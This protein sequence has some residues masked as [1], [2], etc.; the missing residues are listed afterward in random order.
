MAFCAT[1]EGQATIQTLK[2]KEAAKGLL[3][4]DEKS[5]KAEKI[6]NSHVNLFEAEEELALNA[7]FTG[8][9]VDAPENSNKSALNKGII[10]VPLGGN[11]SSNRKSNHKPFYMCGSSDKFAIRD[12]CGRLLNGGDGEGNER[13]TI[14]PAK[15][16]DHKKTIRAKGRTN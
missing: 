11:E 9:I 13:H 7:V 6:R 5:P 14:K 1:W 3:K 15:N 8:K 4:F 2:T 16:D 10:P 12:Y